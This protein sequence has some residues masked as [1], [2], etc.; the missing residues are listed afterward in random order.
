MT[1]ESIY[2]PKVVIVDIYPD[3]SRCFVYI[4]RH[5][6]KHCLST[7]RHSIREDNSWKTTDSLET[8]V[9]II[10]IFF[11]DNVSNCQIRFCLFFFCVKNEIANCN[12]HR[13]L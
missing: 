8:W 12:R 5:T 1:G 10:K 4:C 13:S 2:R 11:N 6:L 9:E 3:W 7:M